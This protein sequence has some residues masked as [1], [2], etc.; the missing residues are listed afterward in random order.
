ML[1]FQG[2]Y[3]QC[4]SA[5][6]TVYTQ[7]SLLS[8]VSS[9][10]HWSEVLDKC[11]SQTFQVFCRHVP[12]DTFYW[13]GRQNIKLKASEFSLLKEKINTFL[14]RKNLKAD[15]SKFFILQKI[16][17]LLLSRSWTGSHNFAPIADGRDPSTFAIK[18]SS[19][20]SASWGRLCSNPAFGLVQED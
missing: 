7:P 9:G 1:S 14:H 19:S 4:L 16:L 5:R 17:N 12:E 10:A 15:S 11:N 3:S 8:G 18:I 2:N 13:Q 20:S 6:E